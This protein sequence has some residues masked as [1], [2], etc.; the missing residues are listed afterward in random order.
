MPRSFLPVR[1]TKVCLC[2]LED[3]VDRNCMHTGNSCDGNQTAC[4]GSASRYGSKQEVAHTLLT[5]RSREL[6]RH[7]ATAGKCI[8]YALLQRNPH[9]KLKLL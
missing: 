4:F 7:T 3:T 6:A 1:E 8:S 2:D 5:Y 9:L